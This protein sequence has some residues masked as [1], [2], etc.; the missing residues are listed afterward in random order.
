MTTKFSFYPIERIE[1]GM[2]RGGGHDDDFEPGIL[3]FQLMGRLTIEDISGLIPDDEFD[4]YKSHMGSWAYDKLGHFRY[5]I[6]HRFPTSD[7]DPVTGERM[8]ESDT[9]HASWKI[10]RSAAAL[11]GLIRPMTQYLGLFH[12]DIGAEG[13]FR[14]IGLDTPLDSLH[15]PINQRNF[16]FRNRDAYDLKVYMPLFLA[17]MDGTFWKFRMALQMH[18]LA[19][20]QDDWQPKFFLYTAALES[21]FTS[22]GKKGQHS[23][24]VV[25]TERIKFFLGPST[26]IYPPGELSSAYPQSNLTVADVVKEIYCLRNHVAHGDRTPAYYSQATGATGHHGRKSHEIRHALGGNQLHYQA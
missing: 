8:Y 11:L 24:S 21:L 18:Q 19:C 10:V 20:Y 9:V 12:G 14:R 13:T 5:A 17:A 23:G 7:V 1:Q 6:V 25:A 26:P 16:G 4:T 15:N 22:Q 2:H 3:P